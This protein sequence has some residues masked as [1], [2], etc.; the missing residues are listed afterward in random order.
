MSHALSTPQ[1]LMAAKASAL[2]G[3]ARVPGDKSISHRSL[4]MGALAVGETHISGLLEGD[5]VLRTAQVMQA[6]GTKVERRAD[7]KAAPTW[8]VWGRGV[9]GL[10]E[11]AD[12][13]DMGNS[14]TGAR[15]IAG[16]LS[17][18][19]FFSVMTG[20]ASL[21]S[22]PMDRV[23][24]PLSQTGAMFQSRAGGKLPMAIRGTPL[25][26]ALTY[27]SPVA[28]AQVKSAVL[29]AG[30]HAPGRT[31]VTEPAASRDHTERM[32]KHFGVEV[33]AG[34]VKPGS[35]VYRA[36]VLGQ[37][38]LTGRPIVVPGDPS[39]AAFPVAAALLIEGS[40]IVVE[41]VGLNPLRTGLFDTL[42]E[43]GAAIE[44]LNTRLEAGEPVA[45]LRVKF[46][47]LKGVHV[48]AERA[49]SMIDEYPIL[50]VAAA[51]AE[52]ETRMEGL[53]ELRV[54]E[55]DRLSAMVNGL[56]ACGV[57]ARAEGDTMIVRG[58]GKPPKG[59][60]TI[61]VH[62]DHRIAM[63]FL[64][65]G[66]VSDKPIGIDDAAAIA[67][68]FPDFIPLMTGLGATLMQVSA[69]G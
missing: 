23:I 1:P 34:P 65:L 42:R 5:D 22:R 64:V 18:Y 20:D 51:C 31:V 16:L 54:K 17:A 12:V 32:F 25:P 38:E 37:P 59:H 52:G 62:L 7:N 36:S 60:A 61:A 45:D 26:M 30:L 3:R 8:H 47:A 41:N 46:S 24:K 39:S 69:K 35:P 58:Q 68:S 21:R 28:S 33:E 40:D 10:T 9:G 15:L 63:S 13:L 66:Q 2:K 27:D 55:S 67:T 11:P 57:D 53:A 6:L 50:A 14:G 19:P 43:M 48:P 49:P 56:V 29:L 4:I 44:T